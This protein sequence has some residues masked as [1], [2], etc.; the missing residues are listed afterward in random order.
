MKCAINLY[1]HSFIHIS[2]IE[3]MRDGTNPTWRKSWTYFGVNLMQKEDQQEDM[4]KGCQALEV[5][6][7]HVL[8]SKHADLDI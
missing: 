4:V 7:M 2:A 1:T 3:M 5:I 6:A 8:L